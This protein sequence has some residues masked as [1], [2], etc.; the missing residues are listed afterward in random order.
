MGATTFSRSKRLK[1]MKAKAAADMAKK[2]E[3]NAETYEDKV[4]AK[5]AREKA[6]DEVLKAKEDMNKF[7]PKNDPAGKPEGQDEV[8][9]DEI[10][11]QKPE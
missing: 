5:A 11:F 1:A 6:E 8:T 2:A 10:V 3:A 4:K 7:Q 9:A